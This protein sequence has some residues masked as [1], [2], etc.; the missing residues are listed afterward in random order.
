MAVWQD[1]IQLVKTIYESTTRLPNDER[2]GLTAQM[3]RAAVSIPSNI[4]EGAARGSDREFA[5]FLLI[6]RGSLSE[7]ETQLTIARELGYL[8]GS[9]FIDDQVDRLF[10]KLGNLLKRVRERL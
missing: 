4:A 1:G 8:N 2:Y 6:A 5:K 10:G 9:S 7:L 3:G